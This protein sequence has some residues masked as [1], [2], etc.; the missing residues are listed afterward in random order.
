MDGSSF[1]RENQAIKATLMYIGFSV[2]KGNPD[3]NHL[4]K[5]PK[6]HN[7]RIH[8]YLLV[9]LSFELDGAN[10]MAEVG[11]CSQAYDPTFLDYAEVRR[12][13]P[14]TLNIPGLD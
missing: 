4:G 2:L 3:F 1:Q 7:K 8:V 14:A 5:P 10:L 11:G 9:F 12:K 13:G 6:E